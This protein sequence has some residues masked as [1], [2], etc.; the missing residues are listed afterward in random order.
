VGVGRR[1]CKAKGDGHKPIR[2]I[3]ASMFEENKKKHMAGSMYHKGDTGSPSLP[4]Y[5]F[6]GNLTGF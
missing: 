4:D 3:D 2:K 1:V 5:N 6:V